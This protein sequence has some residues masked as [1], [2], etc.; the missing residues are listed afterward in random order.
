[1]VENQQNGDQVI[2]FYTNP[3]SLYWD[4]AFYRTNENGEQERILAPIGTYLATITSIGGGNVK[5]RLCVMLKSLSL[6]PH[7]LITRIGRMSIGR[8]LVLI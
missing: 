3:F 6:I 4:R 5:S 1:M 8:R 7:I 2:S